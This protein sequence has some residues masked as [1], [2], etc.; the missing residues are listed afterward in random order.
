MTSIIGS[1]LIRIVDD[2]DYLNNATVVS[3]KTKKKST[4]AIFFTTI[5]FN[6]LVHTHAGQSLLYQIRH[7]I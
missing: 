1:G 4:V 3:S 5:V 6:I 2:Y 7:S